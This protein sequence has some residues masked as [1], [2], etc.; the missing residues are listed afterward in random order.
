MARTM[1]SQGEIP[2]DTIRA[3]VLSALLVAR[4]VNSG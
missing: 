4:V 2:C 1:K 3:I